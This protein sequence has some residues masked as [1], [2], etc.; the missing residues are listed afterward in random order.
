[1]NASVLR[2]CHNKSRRRGT[3]ARC[4]LTFAR[5]LLERLL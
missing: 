4:L 2:R 1:M 5:R 3:L